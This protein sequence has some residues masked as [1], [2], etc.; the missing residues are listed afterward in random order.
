MKLRWASMVVLASLLARA[1]EAKDEWLEVRSEHFTVLTDAGKG[2]ARDVLYDLE[3]LRRLITESLPSQRVDSYVPTSIFVFKNAKSFRDFQPLRDGEPEDW[4][5]VFRST[6]FKS[7]IA[8]RAEGDRDSIRELVFEQYLHLLMSYTDV[9]YPVWLSNGLSLFY[10]NAY[11]TKDHAELGKMHAGHRRELGEFRSMPFEKLFA[12][13]YD[14][15]EYRETY[16]RALFDAQSWALVHYILVGLNPQGA[17]ALGNFLVLLADGK[18]E[19]L[20][21]QEAMKAPLPE[22][23]SAVDLYIRKS[24]SLYMKIPLAPLDIDRDFETT[25]LAPPAA[26]ADLGELLIAMGRFDDARARLSAAAEADPDLA[27]PYEGLGFLSAIEGSADKARSFLERAVQNGSDDPVVHFHYAQSLLAP[28][29]GTVHEI[30]EEVRS[31]AKAS[32]R[33]TLDVSPTHVDAARLY[34]FLCLFGAGELEEGTAVVSKALEAHRGQPRLLFI[35]GQLYA[36]QGSYS[37][38]RTIFESLLARKI[39]PEL[40]A[41]VRLQ[42]DWVVAKEKGS[43]ED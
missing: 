32:L 26:D 18:D 12:V 2:R 28:Y 29:G 6:T 19:L 41:Q 17:E 22:L 25:V 5:A 14:S 43:N 37:P 21:F 3:Q 42:L 30:P 8:L 38:A 24:I 27:S 11:I 9:E 10:G 39:S 20:A 1:G 15:P 31:A 40:V 36:R 33:K 4:A 23:E 34:G 35:L 7:F 13:T 16:P